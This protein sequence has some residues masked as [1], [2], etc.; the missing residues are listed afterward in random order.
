MNAIDF[1]ELPFSSKASICWSFLWRGLAIT[2]ASSLA[3]ALLGGIAGALLGF[4]LNM[5]GVPQSSAM[6]LIQIV[7]GLL[8]LACGVFFLS[9]YVRWLLSAQLGKF[10]LLLVNAAEI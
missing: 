3:G 6:S 2:I 1:R 5:S 7:G 10:K 9:V 4:A 8:G